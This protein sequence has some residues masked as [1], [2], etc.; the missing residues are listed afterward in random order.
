MI[1]E[2]VV[3]QMHRGVAIHD[4]ASEIAFK[5]TPLVSA[6]GNR[7]RRRIIIFRNEKVAAGSAYQCVINLWQDVGIHM[8]QHALDEDQL[9]RLGWYIV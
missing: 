7:D 9:E 3:A 2:P 8:D 1:D 5:K 6:I 4:L